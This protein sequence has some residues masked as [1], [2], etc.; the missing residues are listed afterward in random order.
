MRY[1]WAWQPSLFYPLFYHSFAI[2]FETMTA[3]NANVSRSD[4]HVDTL[5][6][7]G[8]LPG[9]GRTGTPPNMRCLDHLSAGTF[10]VPPDRLK[11]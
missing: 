11:A 8:N 5:L 7:A 1:N 3:Q 10:L 6:L 4:I 2:I 9:H